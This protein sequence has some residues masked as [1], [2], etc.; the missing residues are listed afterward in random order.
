[1]SY[2]TV[3]VNFINSQLRNSAPYIAYFVIIAIHRISTA[4][5]IWLSINI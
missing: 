4:S 2:A 5:G 1:M 3:S